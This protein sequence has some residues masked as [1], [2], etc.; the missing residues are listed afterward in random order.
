MSEQPELLTYQNGGG[1]VRR[2]TEALS[3]AARSGSTA[4]HVGK[5]MALSSIKRP[6]RT[7]R[8]R[9]LRSS[10]KSRGLI[11]EL[12]RFQT[13][14]RLVIAPRAGCDPQLACVRPDVP[15]PLTF[16]V[17]LGLFRVSH[18]ARR[19][20]TTTTTKNVSIRVRRHANTS[21]TTT[22]TFITRRGVPVVEVAERM[23]YHNSADSETEVECRN[24][25]YEWEYGGS[26]PLCTCPACQLKTPVESDQ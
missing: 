1:H 5:G 20:T 21:G 15:A 22:T 26:L 24:C 9:G 12:V 3:E 6:V 4:G 19:H 7:T 18:C 2:D 8:L 10:E 17:G 25:G 14:R 16:D 23:A 13:A 11:A